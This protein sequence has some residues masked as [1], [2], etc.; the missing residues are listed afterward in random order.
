[1]NFNFVDQYKTIF[2]LTK[3]HHELIKQTYPKRQIY[4]F[5]AIF[6]ATSIGIGWLFDLL[7]NFNYIFI[8]TN[9][10][11][12]LSYMVYLMSYHK[13]LKFQTLLDH[14]ILPIL[15]VETSQLFSP[16]FIWQFVIYVLY[17]RF[18]G[19]WLILFAYTIMSLIAIAI[20]ERAHKYDDHYM[21]SVLSMGI[22]LSVIQILFIFINPIKELM[23][24]Y[25]ISCGVAMMYFILMKKDFNNVKIKKTIKYVSTYFII[26]GLLLSPFIITDG[27]FKDT[28]SYQLH[29]D[30]E[31]MV[32]LSTLEDPFVMRSFS[33][34]NVHQVDDLTIVIENTFDVHGNIFKK[35]VNI[36]DTA[37][38]RIHQIEAPHP[39]AAAV[40]SNQG[41]YMTVN[42]TESNLLHGAA[43]N[44]DEETF[45]YLFRITELFT[46]EQVFHIASSEKFDYIYEDESGFY[47][48]H[49]SQIGYYHEETDQFEWQ[50]MMS[51]EDV[52][53]DNDNYFYY[54]HNNQVYTNMYGKINHPRNYV[55]FW[56]NEILAYHQGYA[57]SYTGD[58]A[59]MNFVFTDIE[60]QNVT[61]IDSL[62]RVPENMMMINDHQFVV[63]DSESRMID[64]KKDK[65]YSVMI[66]EESFYLQ[67]EHSLIKIEVGDSLSVNDLTMIDLKDDYSITQV[68]NEVNIPYGYFLVL[69]VAYIVVILFAKILRRR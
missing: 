25:M 7:D 22:S 17:F 9:L 27:I 43:F 53:E 66:N 38:N 44:P 10:I 60:N 34:L 12:V 59:D 29:S 26:A 5:V 35:Y 19:L 49:E 48:F 4:G 1:M 57:I 45:S 61:P 13:Y 16:L 52:F 67:Q 8:T 6:I 36:Y 51:L 42:T 55:H 68:V 14:S 39:Y 20:T 24:N 37:G 50:D 18:S 3:K 15:L 33:H 54:A 56:E 23:P 58:Y 21:T 40:Q 11:G 63:F 47:V 31:R 46:M 30:R 64:V 69:A 2:D 28:F 62:K 32:H 65:S 41:F